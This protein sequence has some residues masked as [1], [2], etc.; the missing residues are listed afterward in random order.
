MTRGLGDAIVQWNK[1]A[2][3]LDKLCEESLNNLDSPMITPE[4][5]RER[6]GGLV[7]RLKTLERL[8]GFRNVASKN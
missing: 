4:Q 5:A 6:L 2:R 7:R 1:E 8:K 3:E